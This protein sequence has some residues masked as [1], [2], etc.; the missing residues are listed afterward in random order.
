V[1]ISSAKFIQGITRDDAILYDGKPQVAFIGRSNVGKSTAIN[2]LLN[3]GELAK[4]GKKQ[5]KTTEINFFLVNDSMYFVDLPG[6][7]FAQ[8][9][10]AVR[11]M[12]R[13]MI[14]SYLTNPKVSPHTIVVIID[15]KVGLTDFDRD[16]VDILRNEDRHAIILLNKTDK[17]NQK[18]LSAQV[19]AIKAEVPEVEIVPY[20]A[21]TKKGSAQVLN[22]ITL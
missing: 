16:I 3:K 9:G 7:G 12:I 5:G 22:K 8:G 4:T 13:A 21:L 6:Y 11:E 2:S 15:A 18:E 19:A 20:S 1:K 14:I 10:H 17:L